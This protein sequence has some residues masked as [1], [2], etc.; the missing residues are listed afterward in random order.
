RAPQV[1]AAA[2]R[3]L[4]AVDAGGPDV[5]VARAEAGLEVRLDVVDGAGARHAQGDRLAEGERAEAV[6]GVQDPEQ[7]TRGGEAEAGAVGGDLAE[8]LGQRVGD[9]LLLI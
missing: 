9:P 4:Q 6:L 3:R 2:G 5:A 1:G 7:A 8:V